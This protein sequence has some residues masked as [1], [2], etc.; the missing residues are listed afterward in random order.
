MC[1]KNVKLITKCDVYCTLLN[2][3]VP[4]DLHALLNLSLLLTKYLRNSDTVYCYRFE[5]FL[6]YG[7]FITIGLL[8]IMDTDCVHCEI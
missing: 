8:F 7:R 6:F 3:C 1:V 2:K 4:R 5:N